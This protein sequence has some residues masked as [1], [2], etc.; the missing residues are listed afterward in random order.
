MHLTCAYSNKLAARQRQQTNLNKK[1]KC[2]IE[3][4]I[5]RELEN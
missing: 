3:I 2:R 5:H 4:I 1:F